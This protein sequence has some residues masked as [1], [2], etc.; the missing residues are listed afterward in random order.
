MRLWGAEANVR[1]RDHVCYHVSGSAWLVFSIFVEVEGCTY[2]LGRMM[3]CLWV[4]AI[5]AVWHRHVGTSCRLD[6]ELLVKARII[7]ILC[8]C[9]LASTSTSCSC[10]SW[11]LK[12]SPRSRRTMWRCYF[13]RW[14]DV[15]GTVSRRSRLEEKVV[16]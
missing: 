14:V 16:L 15:I 6:L 1:V 11:W 5:T 7:L 4:V 13:S 8:Y 3:S 10:V 9:S 2:S 12:A